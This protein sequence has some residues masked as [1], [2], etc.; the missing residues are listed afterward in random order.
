MKT[1]TAEEA[2]ARGVKV[3]K[4][5]NGMGKGHTDYVTWVHRG[6]APKKGRTQIIINARKQEERAKG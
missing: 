4:I 3:Q 2:I 1:E 6:I 5:P